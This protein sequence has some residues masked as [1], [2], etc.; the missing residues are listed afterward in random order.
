[1][2]K[3]FKIIDSKIFDKNVRNPVNGEVKKFFGFYI[4]YKTPYNNNIKQKQSSFDYTSEADAKV[5][6][7]NFLK[8]EEQKISDTF[9]NKTIS[10]EVEDKKNIQPKEDL[11]SDDEV[12][13]AFADMKRRVRGE[14]F[15]EFFRKA[16]NS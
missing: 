12:A 9:V 1:M 7:N 15:S 3:F 10:Q 16:T 13:Q 14:S 11:M 2:E 8:S 5:G 4:K 6:I